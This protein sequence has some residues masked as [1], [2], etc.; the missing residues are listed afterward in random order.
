[1]HSPPSVENEQPRKKLRMENEGRH[2]WGTINQW[3]NWIDME[4]GRS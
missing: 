4:L 2:G 1:M 3:M